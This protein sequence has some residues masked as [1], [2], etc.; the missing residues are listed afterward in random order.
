MRLLLLSLL[1]SAL[2]ATSAQAGPIC[3]A[4]RVMIVLDR[5]SSMNELVGSTS[6]WEIAKQTLQQLTT[7]Y[8]QTIDFGLIVFPNPSYCSPGTMLVAPSTKS[9]AAILAELATPP[10]PSSNGTPMAQTLEAAA[11]LPALL[12]PGAS[13]HVLLITDGVQWCS[14]CDPFD[15]ALRFWPVS[16]VAALASAGV[17]THVV[18][19]GDAVDPLALNKMAAAGGTK[20]SPTCDV[21][22]QDPKATNNCYYQASSASDLLAALQKIAKNVTAEVCDGL[23]ND[24]DGVVDDGLLAPACENG[25]GVCAGAVRACGGA[26]GWK[27]CTASEYGAAAAKAGAAYQAVETLC[28]GKD[29]DCDGTIDEG[30]DCLD[31]ARR[32]CGSA[33]GACAMGFQQCVSGKW[34][35]CVGGVKPA[36]ELCDG[37][38]NDCDG[39]IDEELSRTCVTACGSGTEVCAQGAWLGCTARQPTP[40]VCDGVDNDCDGLVDGPGATCETGI[41][42]A[43]VCVEEPAPRAPELE[44]AAGGCDCELHAPPS[45][46]LPLVLLLLGGVLLLARRPR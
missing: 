20:V 34:S 25:K 8:E 43:G 4:P 18:G 5:S 2:L 3:K 10:T 37:V 27:A 29:N 40:E 39:S 46:P 19:F 14:A 9:A 13:N 24:C 23:D 41:C 22:G 12:D 21:A 45:R 1:A 17:K 32:S 33:V 16:A 30:C 31:G 28:D 26:V 42:V 38:D 6:K 36:A 44:M 35:A 11:K 15:P 7:A